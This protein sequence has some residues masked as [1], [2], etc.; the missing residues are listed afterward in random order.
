[1]YTLLYASLAIPKLI[2][3]AVGCAVNSDFKLYVHGAGEQ[4]ILFKVKLY[5]YL[6]PFAKLYRSP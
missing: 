3:F 4:P 6:L 2:A 1:M 5:C